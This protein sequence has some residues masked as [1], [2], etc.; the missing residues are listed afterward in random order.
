MTQSDISTFETHSPALDSSNLLIRTEVPS[1]AGWIE[2]L[3]HT[4]FGPGRFARAAFRIRERFGVELSLCLVSELDNV[5]VANV[6][7][8]PISVAGLNGYL[9]GPLVTDPKKRNL[10]AGKLL[11]RTVVAKGFEKPKSAFVLLVGDAPYY[12]P[13]GFEPTLPNRIKFPAP[14]DP[15]R[16]LVSTKEAGMVARLKGPISGWE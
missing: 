7:M 16:V 9:L 14:V 6:K 3:H 10:G 15:A 4:C 8:S 2:E 12:G 5:P 11:V 13:L 1:D